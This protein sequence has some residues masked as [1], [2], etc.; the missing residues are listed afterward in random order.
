MTDKT[1]QQMAEEY[2]REALEE[3]DER[4]ANGYGY[5]TGFNGGEI[6]DAFLAGH[7]AGRTEGKAEGRRGALEWVKIQM[8]EFW[9]AQK[10]GD[11]EAMRTI[12]D[13]LF[14]EMER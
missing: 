7:A 4:I 11:E 9:Q 8:S 6:K 2:M 13:R 12:S 5:V 10:E 14:T 3:L 1:P